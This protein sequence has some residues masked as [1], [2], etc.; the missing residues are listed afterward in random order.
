MDFRRL[1]SV[2]KKDAHPLTHIEDI[3]DTLS[4]AKVFSTLDLKSGYWQIEMDPHSKEQT[5]FVCHRGLFQ[6][7]RM[8]FGLCNAPGVFQRLMNKVLAPYIGRSTMVYLDDIVIYSHTE[9]EHDQ[10]LREVFEALRAYGLKVKPS[11]CQFRI[12]ELKL[13]GHIVTPAGIRTDP[14]KVSAIRDMAPP[15]DVKGVRSFLGMTGYYRQYIPDYARVAQPL[16][17]LTKKHSHF[18]W[19]ADQQHAW[20]SLRDLLVSTQVMAYPQV[21]RPYT[22]YTD[23]CDYAV[24]AILV[25]EDEHGVERPIQYISKQLSGAQLK[26]ATIEKEAFAVV[27]ALTKLRPYLYDASFTIYTDHKPL[28]ALFVSEIKNTKIQRWAVLIA[29]YG[30][31]IE[32]RKGPNNMLSRIRP[33]ED[34]DTNT[35]TICAL[36]EDNEVP[37]GFDQLDKQAVQ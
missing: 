15:H 29:E 32:Y 10:H 16:V 20:E 22:L 28:K 33:R 36:H 37:W 1:N 3:F 2:T 21:G 23:A 18:T 17:Q 11:K 27:H 5:A 4:G 34:I 25:Q 24:G 26:W 30:A 9:E 6:F 7:C 35:A 8:P 14:D 12:P 19:T 13:L 31:P